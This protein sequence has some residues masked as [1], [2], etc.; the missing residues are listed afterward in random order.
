MLLCPFMKYMYLIFPE[1]GFGEYL[2]YTT[3]FQVPNL[4]EGDHWFWFSIHY[5]LMFTGGNLSIMVTMIGVFLLF[6]KNYYPSY[7]VGV[8]FGYILGNLVMQLIANSNESLNN[9]VGPTTVVLCIAIAI[10]GFAV[11]D[12]LLFKDNHR[13][14][15]SEARLVGLIN[16]PGMTWDDKEDLLKKEA[17]RMM[18]EDNELFT[19]AS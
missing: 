11:T 9:S 8:P 4:I 15:A 2:L 17:K 16:M 13:K 10:V 5:F 1:E 6:P 12:H 18:K 7:L 19:K 3:Y 14:R